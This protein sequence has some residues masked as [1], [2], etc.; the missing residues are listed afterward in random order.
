[1]AYRPT[2]PFL[3]SEKKGEYKNM[4]GN[5]FVEI[6]LSSVNHIFLPYCFET[7]MRLK[8]LRVLTKK[9][10]VSP[11]GIKAL[12]VI[13]GAN[14]YDNICE[15]GENISVYHDNL[16]NLY[17]T[18]DIAGTYLYLCYIYGVMGEPV[19][20]PIQ[21]ISSYRPAL[22]VFLEKLIKMQEKYLQDDGLLHFDYESVNLHD[23][24]GYANEAAF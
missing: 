1:L 10:R 12:C 7:E 19:P 24:G 4:T 2:E 6:A 23:D 18:G 15:S 21:W 17:D 9:G 8:R 5:E 13:F 14:L 22:T 3:F 20:E 11:P 16:V